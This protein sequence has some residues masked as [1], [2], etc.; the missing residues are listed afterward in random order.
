MPIESDPHPFSP[1]NKIWYH[2]LSLPKTFLTLTNNGHVK[3]VL[4]LILPIPVHGYN[5]SV[6]KLPGGRRGL[7]H[8]LLELLKLGPDSNIY[9]TI[10]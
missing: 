7:L 1:Y 2:F 9:L 4:G 6:A 3:K 10:I 5:G 8:T